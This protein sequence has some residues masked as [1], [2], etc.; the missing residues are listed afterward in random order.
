MVKKKAVIFYRASDIQCYLITDDLE[1]TPNSVE[2]TPIKLS[3]LTGVGTDIDRAF[4][5]LS[6]YITEEYYTVY[7][8]PYLPTWECG[9]NFWT[10]DHPSAIFKHDVYYSIFSHL[11]KLRGLTPTFILS[12]YSYAFI[13]VDFAR[14]FGSGI[15]DNMDYVKS[16]KHSPG[17]FIDICYDKPKSY[18]ISKYIAKDSFKYI[19]KHCETFPWL[20]YNLIHT[21]NKFE[22]KRRNIYKGI[23]STIAWMEVRLFIR[24]YMTDI[25]SNIPE[26]K[27]GFLSVPKYYHA[28][29]ILENLYN[30]LNKSEIEEVQLIELQ[31]FL[32][33]KYYHVRN[34]TAA[35]N[36]YEW[37]KNYMPKHP[38]YIKKLSKYVT[39]EDIA[40]RKGVQY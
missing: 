31:T 35:K 9:I 36:M 33:E 20:K 27:Y 10:P 18:L 32:L 23:V 29:R 5:I 1:N 15:M 28:Q 11:H 22:V 38:V 26:E 40:K 13:G 21:V 17:T 34:I 7:A 25:T 39:L 37:Y 14:Y 2:I 24:A 16:L 3:I 6:P 12:G 19:S 4:K 30:K 8:S